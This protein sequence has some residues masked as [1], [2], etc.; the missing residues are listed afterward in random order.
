MLSVLA[1][2]SNSNCAS[3]VPVSSRA[4]AK[5]STVTRIVVF[6]CLQLG[7]RSAASGALAACTCWS[8]KHGS[9]IMLV[10]PH[11]QR[12]HEQ[13][14]SSWGRGFLLTPQLE[15]QQCARRNC[16]S[17]LMSRNSCR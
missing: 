11:S 7:P 4:R 15:Q 6:G 12:R 3:L 2:S 1:V 10:A 17:A 5:N 9:Q 13:F 16:S 14:S 8:H